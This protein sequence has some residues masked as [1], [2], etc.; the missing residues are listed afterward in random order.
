MSYTVFTTV[1]TYTENRLVRIKWNIIIIITS[2]QKKSYAI[3]DTKNY[4]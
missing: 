2:K 1:I 3:K 4:L